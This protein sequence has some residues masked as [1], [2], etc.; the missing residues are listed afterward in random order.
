MVEQKRKPASLRTARTGTICR[1]YKYE[2]NRGI[3][4]ATHNAAANHSATG[5]PD[6]RIIYKSVDLIKV[7]RL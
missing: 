4:P 6:N 7:P 2:F 3:E 1:T 5:I